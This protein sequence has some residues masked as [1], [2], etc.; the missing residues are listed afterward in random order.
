[1][2]LRVKH[3]VVIGSVRAE[4]V[5]PGVLCLEGTLSREEARRE[6]DGHL[7]EVH[8][9]ALAHKLSALTIDVRRLTFANSSAIR[10]FV[11]MTSRAERAGYK[12]IFEIDPSITWHRLNF[13]VLQSLAPASVELRESKAVPG[14]HK[15]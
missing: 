9:H 7:G 15:R 4:L 10:L 2:A 8:T 5:D 13:S 14:S 1:M 12:L 3:P 11:D 6:L